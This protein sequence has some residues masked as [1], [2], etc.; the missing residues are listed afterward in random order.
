MG[1]EG[2]ILPF[3]DKHSV[4]AILGLLGL[5]V[6]LVIWNIWL[7]WRI[8]LIRAYV[9]ARS[10]GSGGCRM[11]PN[12]SGT[13]GVDSRLD[14]NIHASEPAEVPV[15]QRIG[16]V[17]FD[18]FDDVGGEQSFALALLD[19]HGSGVV[20]SNLFGRSESRMYAKCI[21]EG[22]PE[23]TLSSE[24]QEAV[25]RALECRPTRRT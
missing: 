24:E 19:A 25:R 8:R 17:R 2:R 12:G 6:C 18:A 13:P 23:H 20:L 16:L 9:K 14:G 11:E 5:V 21:T 10:S 4:S 22:K 3:L 1:F 7:T 15:T